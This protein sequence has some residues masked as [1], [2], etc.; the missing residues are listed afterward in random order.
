MKIPEYNKA[1]KKKKNITKGDNNKS[2]K[3]EETTI[4]SKY[5]YP[6]I[7]SLSDTQKIKVLNYL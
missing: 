6:I 5:I 1:N 7:E 3:I 4:A 2:R